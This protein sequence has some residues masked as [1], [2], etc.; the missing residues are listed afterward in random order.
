MK[1]AAELSPNIL[2]IAVKDKSK[3]WEPEIEETYPLIYEGTIKALKNSENALSVALDPLYNFAL[4][5]AD[6]YILK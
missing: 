1:E 5:A 2:Q 3:N 6:G 4:D